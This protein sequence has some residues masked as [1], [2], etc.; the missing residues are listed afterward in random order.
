MRRIF[1]AGKIH[2]EMAAEMA[3]VSRCKKYKKVLDRKL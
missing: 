1:L 3:V 2:W